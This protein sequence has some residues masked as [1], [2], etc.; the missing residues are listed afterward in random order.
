LVCGRVAA[1]GNLQ[2]R[3]HGGGPL[4]GDALNRCPGRNPSA[5]SCCKGKKRGVAC[6]EGEKR[7]SPPRRGMDLFV[8]RI[9][10]D[11]IG[12]DVPGKKRRGRFFQRRVGE[13][14]IGLAG[15]GG[16]DKQD[17]VGGRTYRAAAWENSL[18]RH[19]AKGP[20]SR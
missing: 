5:R 14:E 6:I 11:R 8:L 20:S 4:R 16:R 1:G 2:G 15:A 13:E 7:R 9:A 19:N 12:D 10:R 17:Q 18:R 3:R